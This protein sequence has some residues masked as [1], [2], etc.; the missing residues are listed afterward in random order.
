MI[1]IEALRG[2]RDF[3]GGGVDRRTWV[4]YIG[5]VLLVTPPVSAVVAPAAFEGILATGLVLY[6]PAFGVLLM[7]LDTEM[8]RVPRDARM[9][10]GMA[11]TALLL[12]V[13][14]LVRQP[15]IGL[16]VGLVAALAY[17]YLRRWRRTPG[18]AM[19]ERLDE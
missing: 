6:L 11:A 2:P 16:L 4:W 19:V 13:T 17:D 18:A 10:L 14:W 7:A 8:A 3:A 12:V 1:A 5:S 15:V 9:L